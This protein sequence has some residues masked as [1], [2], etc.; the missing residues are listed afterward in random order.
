[1][2]FSFLSYP[3]LWNVTFLST[4]IDEKKAKIL[5][6]FKKIFIFVQLHKKE[7]LFLWHLF[8]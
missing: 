3:S 5:S 7:L 2:A 1:M 4:Y 6:I 8:C